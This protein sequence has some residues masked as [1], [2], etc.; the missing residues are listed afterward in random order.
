MRCLAG[1][2][3]AS[4][5]W[6][7]AFQVAPPV[8]RVAPLSYFAKR[9]ARC[10]GPNGS[11]FGKEFGKGITDAQLV[12]VVREMTEGPGGEPLRGA[13][14]DALVAWHRA[15]IRRE[16]FLVLLHRGNETWSGECTP[17]AKVVALDGGRRIPAKV[18]GFRWSM[19]PPAGARLVLEARVEARTTRLDPAS[20]SFSHHEPLGK[21][22]GSATAPKSGRGAA[23]VRG[24][25]GSP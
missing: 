14:L 6:T 18:S 17:G 8:P 23:V 9:C 15:L 16:P 21:G 5:L 10:H 25:A 12:R 22:E 2:L 13:D 1:A 20:R 3:A 19:T 4:A 24:G 7:A 11:N